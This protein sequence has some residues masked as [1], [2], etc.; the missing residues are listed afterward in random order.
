MNLSPLTS[1]TD[2]SSATAAGTPGSSVTTSAF[3]S[4]LALETLAAAS[5]GLEV[6]VLEEGAVSEDA[7]AEEGEEGEI[8]D[9][10]GFLA[11]LTNP[12]LTTRTPAG[13][14]AGGAAA[15][16]DDAAVEAVAG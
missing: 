6:A 3:D 11:S 15:N 2:T 13:Q 12:A 5:P 14:A 7:E 9:L 4:I 1:A 10:L 8:E 16:S